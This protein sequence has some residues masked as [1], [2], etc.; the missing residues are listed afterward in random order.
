MR[1]KPLIV[2]SSVIANKPLNGGNARMVLNW[3]VGLE[4]LGAEVFLIEQLASE[5]CVDDAGDPTVAGVSANRRYFESVLRAHR[6]G[7]RAALVCDAGDTLAGAT[8]HGSTAAELDDLARDADL[9]IN[10]SGHL[11]TRATRSFGTRD[12]QVP[13]VSRTTMSTSRLASASAR[14]SARFPPVASGGSRSASPSCWMTARSANRPRSIGSRP[15][16]VGEA[17]SRRSPTREKRIV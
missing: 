14:A 12:R 6:F 16:P 8:I 11:S 15:S 2:L 1:P 17:P 5:T 9:L 7:D 13:H 3:L 4:R 10:I